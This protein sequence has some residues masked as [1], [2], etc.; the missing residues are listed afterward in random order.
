MPCEDRSMA[1]LSPRTA[2]VRGRAGIWVSLSVWTAPRSLSVLTGQDTRRGHLP[3]ALHG[4]TCDLTQPGTN[5]HGIQCCL[6]SF[7]HRRGLGTEWNRPDQ[8]A[9]RQTAL[10]SVAS[11]TH[12]SPKSR[13]CCS[14]VMASLPRALK[15]C[16]FLALRASRMNQT[17]SSWAS[18][19]STPPKS[20]DREA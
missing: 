11:A 20:E 19:L 13:G 3:P 17:S 12:G 4:T 5:L 8:N 6:K 15:E 16:V 10:G 9:L 18:C 14:H 2:S 7:V 1:H